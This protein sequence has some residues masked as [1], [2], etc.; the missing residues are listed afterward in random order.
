MEIQMEGGKTFF[1]LPLVAPSIRQAATISKLF[2]LVVNPRYLRSSLALLLF[3]ALAL[4]ACSTVP[5]EQANRLSGE[6]VKLLER[7]TRTEP[8]LTAKSSTMKPAIVAM[9]LAKSAAQPVFTYRYEGA[10]YTIDDYLKR[11]PVTALLIAKNGAIVYERYQFGRTAQ[12]YY[13]SNSIAKSFT[14]LAMGFA[15]AEG[16]IPSFDVLAQSYV[17]ALKGMAYGETKLRNLMRMGSG[18]RFIET[19]QPNDDLSKF[20]NVVRKDGIVNA[21][22]QFNEREAPQGSRFYYAGV[23][24]ALLSAV[25]QSATGASVASF[26][27]PRLWQAIGAEGAAYWQQDPTG[28]NMTHCCITALPHDYLRLGVILANNG[29]RPD[30]GKQVIPRE[31]LFDS[32]DWHRVDEPFKPYNKANRGTTGY[33]NFF[34]LQTSEARRFMMLGTY[35]QA[36]FVDPATKLVMVHFAVNSSVHMADTTM[37]RERGALWR[38]VVQH[39]GKW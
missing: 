30:T 37:D 2:H 36:I 14:G 38:A 27:E 25:I 21:A 28:L 22:K 3:A 24:P 39:Y 13:L 11:Q 26:L 16:K 18:V 7:H 17:P 15:Q 19:H 29:K 32:T 31:Y 35:G 8:S 1:A 12:H 20:G 4:C 5:A 10:T 23:E 34:W 6:Q 9:P 33:G